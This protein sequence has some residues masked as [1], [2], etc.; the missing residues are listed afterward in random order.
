MQNL[1]LAILLLQTSIGPVQVPELPAPTREA[2]P[3]NPSELAILRAGD[4]LYEQGKFDDAARRYDEV[5]KANP[6]NV[7]AMHQL[8][9]T[10]FQQHEYQ[11]AVDLAINGLEFKSTIRPLF[12][13][14]IGN[15]LDITGQYQ[16]AVDTY[17]SGLAIAPGSGILHYNLGVTLN[18]SLKD[19]AQGRTAF[20]QGALAD[21]NYPGIQ[22]QLAA[23]FAMDDLKT[24]ALLASS[25][26]L[27]LDPTSNRAATAYN[28]WRQMLNGNAR[29]PDQNGQ[30]QILVNPNQKKDEG[31]L[32]VLDMD[33]SMSKVLAL[34]ASA[35]KS[36]MQ[37]MFE[38]VDSLFKMYGTR[39]AGEDKDKMVWTYYIPYVAEMQQ[40]N[41][42]EPFVYYVSQRTTIPGVREWLAA[43]PG[44][45]AAFLDWSKDYSWPKD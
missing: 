11:K 19:A 41:F 18:T 8:A 5:L 32:Q 1:M 21:P 24:P 12:Y 7:S 20:K 45:V 4:A 42:V 10:Y 3:N 29:P 25:R 23:S 35:G 15:T 14:L 44:R 2:L 40:K 16:R 36:Q 37:S 6:N 17:R 34:K 30:I 27:V 28:M 26:Y 38:Q 9:D 31:N 43:N 22:F 39:P 33:I 13:V